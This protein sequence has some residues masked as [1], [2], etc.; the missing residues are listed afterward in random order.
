MAQ[1][2]G[3]FRIGK[4]AVLR[5]TDNSSV[6]N[7]A[8]AS[9]YGKKDREGNRNT[10]WIDASLWGKR[11]ESLEQYLLKGQQVY[12]VISEPHMETYETRDGGKAASSLA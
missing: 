8:L 3:V 4:D 5:Q 11:A 7:L 2:V 1:I 12:C 9:N 10:Q 6:I